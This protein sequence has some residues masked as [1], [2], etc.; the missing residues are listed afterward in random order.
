MSSHQRINDCGFALSC[1]RS[2]DDTVDP[3]TDL[4][5][6]GHQCHRLLKKNIWQSV[7]RSYVDLVQ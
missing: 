3:R 4:I 5:D 6:E 7:P 1:A 2:H